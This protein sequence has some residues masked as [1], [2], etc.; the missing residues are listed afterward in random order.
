M[1]LKELLSPWVN[2]PSES[3]KKIT[4][5]SLDSREI[6][7]GGLFMALAGTQRNGNFF[8]SEAI[9]K[10]AV[11]ILFNDEKVSIQTDFKNTLKIGLPSLKERYAEISARFWNRP[12]QSLITYGVTGTNGKTSC[13]HF[14]A[15]LLSQLGERAGVI[16]TL[17]TGVIGS[18]KPSL[19]T[20]P[21]GI[22]IQACLAQMREQKIKHVAI[23]VSSHGLEQHRVDSVEF[24][25]GLLTNISHDHLDYHKNFEAYVEVKQQLFTKFNLAHTLLNMN[26]FY[27]ERWLNTWQDKPG[28]VAYGIGRPRL[29]LKTNFLVA[30]ELVCNQEGSWARLESSWGKGELNTQLL[31]AFNI[32]NIL[33][34]VSALL[35]EGWPF[36]KVLEAI[37]HL[38]PVSGR[39][40]LFRTQ[41]QPSIVID[42]AHT[43]DALEKVL[44]NL[45][46]FNPLKL[47]CVFGCGGNR[48]TMK[49]PKMGAAVS[50]YADE[51][52]ITDDNSRDEDPR[53][54]VQEIISGIP[55]GKSYQVIH[56]R[57][58]A[59]EAAIRSAQSKDIILIAGKG[60]ESY[61]EAGGKRYYFNDSE[62][63]KQCLNDRA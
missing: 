1:Q 28:L 55:Q 41:G 46:R 21:N 14:I 13:T 43:P 62:V 9:E 10:G 25:S 37:P 40:Q 27:G 6:F 38:S 45:K 59:I 29:D 24:K 58:L 22:E 8:I 56:D 12:S 17:G 60:H 26:D 63:V 18:L 44:L 20:T 35:A 54:I 16:G 33:A 50:R 42:Y 4:H 15:S 52:I 36:K 11:A 57:R 31:G 19:H 3:D 7:P 48:D 47:W 32:S 53:K 61:Q 39:M 51:F 49:R 34:A 2:I 30:T 5:L 23:E